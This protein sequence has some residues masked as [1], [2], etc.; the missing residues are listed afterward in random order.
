MTKRKAKFVS[1][2]ININSVTPHPKNYRIHSQ[3]QLDHIEKSIRE[4]GFY[5][6]VVVAKDDVI[7]AGHGVVMAAKNIGYKEIPIIRLKVKSNSVKAMRVLA[8][9]NEISRLAET[10][11]RAL[12]ELL[13]DIQDVDVAG[14]LGTGFDEAMLANLAF[15]TRTADE[16]ERMNVNEEWIGMPEFG[17]GPDP[18]KIVIQF[19]NMKDRENFAEHIGA[20][21]TDKTRSL[22]WPLRERDDNAS[23]RWEEE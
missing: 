14:L 18:F 6:N 2:I 9:D 19:D 4:N 1:E 12:T 20:I 8:G 7:L 11:D 23:V 13:K 17:R 22:W 10:D 5:R 21:I 15:V 3:F 16:I